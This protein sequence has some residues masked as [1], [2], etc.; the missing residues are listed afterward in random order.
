MR[1]SDAAALASLDAA[2]QDAVD[3]AVREENERWGRHGIE[4]TRELVG[5]RPAG[6]TPE[7]SAIVQTAVG[8]NR[9]LGLPAS[10]GEG[11]TDANIP[12]SLGIP[13]ITVGGGGR[14]TGAHSLAERFDST[15][16]W[17]GTQR[18][19]ALVFALAR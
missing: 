15:D 11:S 4:A 6:R 7:Q 1:S 9:A 5:D 12:I 3:R 17:K 16:S 18:V 8:V 19:T 10:L 2:F 13:A 14:S